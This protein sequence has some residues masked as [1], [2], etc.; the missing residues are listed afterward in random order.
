[1]RSFNT[2]NFAEDAS[3]MHER[4]TMLMFARMSLP[5]LREAHARFFVNGQYAGIYL[6][7][8]PIDTRFLNTHFD[9][10]DGYLYEFKWTGTPYHFEYLGG[11]SALYVPTHF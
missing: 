5:Y 2:R 9:E 4:L 3:M 10:T 8:E 1:M 11:D 6:I 7:L